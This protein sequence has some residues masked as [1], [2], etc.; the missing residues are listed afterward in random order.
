MWMIVVM[1]QTRVSMLQKPLEPRK[2]QMGEISRLPV[3]VAAV[4]AGVA[5]AGAAAAA[6][7]A[8][9][10]VMKIL[11]TLSES[12]SNSQEASKDKQRITKWILINRGDREE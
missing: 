6:A 12:S 5:V 8:V 11:S 4:E 2:M 1:R 3:L 7:A 9:K 10:T